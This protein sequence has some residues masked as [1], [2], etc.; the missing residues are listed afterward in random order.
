MRDRTKEHATHNEH[1]ALELTGGVATKHAILCTVNRAENRQNVAIPITYSRKLYKLRLLRCQRAA[2]EFDAV[3][4]RLHE[5][6]DVLVVRAVRIAEHVL[7]VVVAEAMQCLLLRQAVQAGEREQFARAVVLSGLVAHLAIGEGGR[8]EV[9]QRVDD[10]HR[11][12]E[13]HAVGGVVQSLQKSV[14]F[15]IPFLS[16]RGQNKRRPTG[17]LVVDAAMII[18]V[19]R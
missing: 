17:R 14:Q 1:T 10:G 3:P 12:V 15:H 4:A 9:V 8:G 11:V 6:A 2:A 18:R 16:R 19:R 7:A 13:C 5:V